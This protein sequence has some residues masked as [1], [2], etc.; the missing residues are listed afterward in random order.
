MIGRRRGFKSWFVEPYRQIKLGLMF[1]LVNFFFSVA[2]FSVFSYYIWNVFRALSVYFSLSESQNQEILAK[3]SVPIFIGLGLMIL[4]ILITILV[5]VRYTHA[6]YG[7]LVSIH[8]FLDDLIGFK[9]VEPITLRESDQLK[10]LAAKLNKLAFRL[11]DKRKAPLVPIYRFLDDLLKGENPEP[12]LLREE[13]QL[14]E[15]CEKLN[16]VAKI[17]KENKTKEGDLTKNSDVI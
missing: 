17:I 2:I 15:L 16:D 9:R 4:F 8:R 5:S 1:L 7:P 12:L 11:D 10:S 3:F 13:D 14:A 6:I